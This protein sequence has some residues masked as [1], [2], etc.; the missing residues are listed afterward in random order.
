MLKIF[1]KTNKQNHVAL[2]HEALE[3]SEKVKFNVIPAKIS[4]FEICL[5]IWLVN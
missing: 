2:R 3:N 1:W 5:P 4:Y